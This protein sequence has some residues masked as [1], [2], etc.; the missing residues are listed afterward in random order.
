D[1]HGVSTHGASR[2][3]IYVR[4]IQK[5]LID[6][7]A[8]LTVERRRGGTLATDAAN[9]LGQVQAVKTLQM[10][11]PMASPQGIAAATIRHSQHFGALS[12]YCNKAAAAD[13]ILFAT[14]NC[15]PAMSPED[16]CQAYFDTNPL[17][18]SFPT[19][20]GWPVKV[21]LATSIVA[22]GNII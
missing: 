16:G 15:E 11:M 3:N 5:G 18:A 4:R 19:A 9:G 22:R 10:L 12:Y 13:M 14:T 2:L 20:R 6:P 8:K 17:A 1:I 7:Q 21:D